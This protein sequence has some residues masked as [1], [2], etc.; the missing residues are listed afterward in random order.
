VSAN[1]TPP[2]SAD[3][4][5]SVL[6]AVLLRN[7]ALDVIELRAEEFYDPRHRE[8][9]AAARALQS[10]HR[11]I[12]PVTIEAELERSGKLAAVGGLGFLSELMGSVP[13]ADNVE[14]YAAIVADAALKRRVIVAASEIAARGFRADLSGEEL[15]GEFYSSAT[16]IEQP[17]RDS[18]VLMADIARETYF[19]LEKSLAARDRGERPD[20]ALATGIATLDAL[21]NGGFPRG[22]MHIIAAR[23]SMGKSALARGICASANAQGAGVHVFSTE[24]KRG[25]YVRRQFADDA[26]VD[27]GRLTSVGLDRI[28]WG[29]VVAAAND[30]TKRE[31]W[32]V[33][34]VRGIS[35]S[36]I[37]L[38]VKRRRKELRTE[39][40]VIDYAQLLVGERG[41]RYES[42]EHQ[43]SEI[44]KKAARLAGDEN[45]VVLLLSQ[46]NRDSEKR[47]DKR[48]SLADLRGSGEL[49]QA[50]D[51]VLMLHRPEWYLLKQL[52]SGNA[53][54]D[55]QLDMWR[56]KGQVLL[57][58]GKN[59]RAPNATVLQWDAKSA[60][61]RDRIPREGRAA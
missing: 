4:E 51:V 10:K 23:P 42:R 28:E 16:Q 50:A 43:V 12:D 8:V 9:F 53:N 35:I 14:H 61:Y 52:E 49:E 26:D 57:E 24:D 21:L 17:T 39:L 47:D 44:A 36:D 38:K 45:V 19:E 32:M 2:H 54:V 34:D 60:T 30:L 46:L 20:V 33:D 58:K 15:L 56:G 18:G 5:A 29:R 55:R 13:T 40:V 48:P 7:D 25:A 59:M 37:A 41:V 22:N 6:G 3:A 1:R 11:P 31:R 27:L